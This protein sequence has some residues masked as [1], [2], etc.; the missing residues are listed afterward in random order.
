MNAYTRCGFL[1]QLMDECSEISDTLL[2][3]T[4]AG[5]NEGIYHEFAEKRVSSID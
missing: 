5:K 3:G 1:Q 2:G 4:G